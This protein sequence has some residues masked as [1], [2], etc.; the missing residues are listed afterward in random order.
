MSDIGEKLVFDW[1]SAHWTFQL[2]LKKLWIR[3]K[4][5]R[6]QNNKT[7]WQSLVGRQRIRNGSESKSRISSDVRQCSMILLLSLEQIRAG[8]IFSTM[9][10]FR[11][12]FT[13]ISLGCPNTS[14]REGEKRKCNERTALQELWSFNGMDWGK[15]LGFM[16]HLF[17]KMVLVVGVVV[18]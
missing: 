7:F 17:T 13:G 2:L 11:R 16:L 12:R 14:L 5:W 18:P 10:T 9:F 4:G 1:R 8:K 3:S 15:C 6:G